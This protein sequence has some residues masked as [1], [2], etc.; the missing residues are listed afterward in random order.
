VDSKLSTITPLSK[1]NILCKKSV[2]ASNPISNRL[3]LSHISSSKV[4]AP[5]SKKRKRSTSNIKINI[6]S[7][8]TTSSFLTN[9][10]NT[11]KL[12]SPVTTECKAQDTISSPCIPLITNSKP[13]N[14]I[15]NHPSKAFSD[16]SSF[17][18]PCVAHVT[19]PLNM[20]LSQTDTLQSPDST[21]QNE[22]VSLQVVPSTSSDNSGYSEPLYL[23]IP[24]SQPTQNN[25]IEFLSPIL[26]EPVKDNSN[27]YP[28]D[29]SNKKHNM[30]PVSPLSQNSNSPSLVP[31]SENS[32]N[33]TN[34]SEIEITETDSQNSSIRYHNNNLEEMSFSS[35]EPSSFNQNSIDETNLPILANKKNKNNK[36]KNV[37]V[38]NKNN[39]DIPCTRCHKVF[40][41]KQN[42]RSHIKNIH[43]STEKIY[44]CP[45]CQYKGAN[46]T[47]LKRHSKIHEKFACKLCSKK[48]IDEF[49]LKNH[50]LTDHNEH[51][52]DVEQ[53]QLP[54]KVE[55]D[56]EIQD[57]NQRDTVNTNDIIGKT[58][59]NMYSCHSCNDVQFND[60]YLMYTHVYTNH[61]YSNEVS[62]QCLLC[63]KILKQKQYL[64]RHLKNV[65]KMI[66]S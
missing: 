28:L 11:F 10:N 21:C 26:N 31:N 37:P 17:I 56:I 5:S 38:N 35:N 49:L 55:N 9:V 19:N 51:N 44:S 32:S 7:A 27:N 29:Y 34:N 65:H 58:V 4:P 59:D 20:D 50:E 47:Y 13:E 54:N 66:F 52:N 2:S 64:K 25:E 42:L 33:Y 53:Q 1:P 40:H 18:S 62:L 16:L 14:L 45:L 23:Y 46:K 36:I 61:L 22:D 24:T 57:N 41:S 3:V 6:P 60:Q 39:V 30:L 15:I 43:E 8:T 12:P 63:S 48:F